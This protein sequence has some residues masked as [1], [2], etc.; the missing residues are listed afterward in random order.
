MIFYGQH[1][2]AIDAAILAAKPALLID[3]TPAGLWHANCNS[4][5]FQGIGIKVFS[6]IYYAFGQNSPA[7][8][9]NGTIINNANNEAFIRAIAAEGTKGVF[10]DCVNPRADAGITALCQYAHSLGLLVMVNAGVS[11]TDESLYAIADYVMVEE[12]YTGQAP[13]S[14]E[15]NYLAQS[16]PIGSSPGWTAQ[17]AAQYSNDAWA[18]GF[19][20]TY[21]C[22]EYVSLPPW[23][24]TYISLLNK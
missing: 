19:M 21:H 20:F 4:A 13:T 14:T 18:Q 15:T 8:T 11:P 10:I 16:I 23:L 24:A 22:Q 2:P 9:I 1:T 17:Q 6:Y 12:D 5:M 7:P 3:N